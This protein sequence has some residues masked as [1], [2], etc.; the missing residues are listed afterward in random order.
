MPWKKTLVYL[1]DIERG[2]VSSIKH[3]AGHVSSLSRVT[4][5]HLIGGFEDGVGQ[6]GR[7][8]PFV[9][10]LL[11]RNPRRV[12][13]QREMDSGIRNQIRLQIGNIDRV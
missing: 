13:N 9:I 5:D 10:S 11:S 7:R 1:I 4:L 2:D 6:F 12:R 3:G 8:Q